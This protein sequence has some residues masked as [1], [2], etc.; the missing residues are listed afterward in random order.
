MKVLVVSS[1]NAG[2]LA[3]F[4][5]EQIDAL[6]AYPIEFDYYF[7]VGK[8][9]FGYLSNIVR[10]NKKINS[11]KPDII[12]AHYGLSGFLALFVKRG[13][14]LVTTFHGND[15][16]PIHSGKFLKPNLNKFL[17]FITSIFSNFSVF[18]NKELASQIKARPGKFSVIPCQVNPVLFYPID[19]PE[20]RR[21]CSL[22]PEKKYILFS[23][24]FDTHIKNS[25]LAKAASRSIKDAELIELKGYSR[26]EVNLLLNACDVALLTSINEG[27]PQFIKEAMACN[28]PIVSTDVGDVRWVIGNTEGCF[29]TGFEPADV[30]EKIQMALEFSLSQGSTYGRERI[31]EL[32]LTSK[33][34][35]KKIVSVYNKIIQ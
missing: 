11:Y 10:L 7:I 32:G 14:P 21:Q 17:S 28:R 31:L 15:I 22:L 6:S 3:P 20:A 18:V 9:I 34:I 33:E 24:S 23:S 12:H 27:S 35:A 13:C 19:K 5:K 30:S 8:G 4:V 2:Q 1:G 26:K 29:I 16:N 25:P